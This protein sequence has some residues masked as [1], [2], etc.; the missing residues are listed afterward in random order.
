MDGNRKCN[1]Q[2][3]SMLNRHIEPS[4]FDDDQL[5]KIFEE[6]ADILDEEG[7][8]NLSFDKFAIVSLEY[9]LFTDEA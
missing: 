9:E 2:E 4:K 8:K 6:N 5:V 3:W 1:F 7:E